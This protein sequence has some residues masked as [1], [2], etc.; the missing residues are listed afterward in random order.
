M[1]TSFDR[2]LQ[3]GCALIG[4]AGTLGAI[5]PAP[6]GAQ[7]RDSIYA[8]YVPLSG[9]IYRIKADKAPNSC[10]R[11]EHVA[12]ALGG[13]SSAKG[14]G[15]GG[16]GSGSPSTD[17]GTLA[18]LADDD[19]P[20]YLLAAGVRQSTNGFAVTGTLGTGTVPVSGGGAR[21]MWYP[22]KAA[23]RAGYVAGDQWDDANVGV[24][25]I[26]LGQH[27]VASGNGSAALGSNARATAFLATAVGYNA[28]A[29]AGSSIALGEGATTDG[30]SSAALGRYAHTTGDAS[31]AIGAGASAS[32]MNSLSLSG[33]ASGAFA[34]AL[35]GL[36]SG[37]NAIAI[38]PNSEA[39]G[40]ASLA[41]GSYASTNGKAG[42][43]VIGD[44][45]ATTTVR[46]QQDNHFVVRAQRF[47]L[48]SSSDATATV[49]RFLETNTGAYLSSGGTWV[50]SSDSTKKHRWQDVDGDAVL[51]KLATLPVRTW[52]YREE[53]DSVRHMG[54][55]AQAFRAAFGLGDT[56]K[57]IATVDADG[58]SLVAAK[59]LERRTRL[60]QDEIAVL[61]AEL[62]A[63]R[64]EL[65]AARR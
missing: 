65:A 22:G 21:L 41:L 56:D 51:E 44:R 10:I 28:V 8:C 7:A 11:P 15:G 64:S 33:N 4:C 19:H 46:A 59:A 29:Q 18:G 17:H 2:T 5:V 24:S 25:S 42:A 3:I 45:S 16:G 55:T 23:F 36:A 63:L 13:A 47:W 53:P 39:S 38:G 1:R 32:G 9:T 54:P 34:V 26:A 40:F 31:T 58:V 62:A 20:Q 48:G 52:S 27:T 60:L 30:P 61:R 43:I 50:S 57:A 37:P 12:F 14:P 49:G 35:K 6:A